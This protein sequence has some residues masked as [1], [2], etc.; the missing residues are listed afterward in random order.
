MAEV[1][2]KQKTTPEIFLLLLLCWKWRAAP[3]AMLE[4][5]RSAKSWSY[6]ERLRDL[7]LTF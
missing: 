2:I 4:V 3:R 1:L 5:A 7:L 6:L